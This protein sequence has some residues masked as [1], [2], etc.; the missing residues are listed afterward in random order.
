MSQSPTWDAL[1]IARDAR[2]S[3][4]PDAATEIMREVDEDL[5]A[6]VRVGAR[7]LN[8]PQTRE[9]WMRLMKRAGLRGR[10]G[11]P[12]AM[13]RVR[14]A[15]SCDDGIEFRMTSWANYIVPI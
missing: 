12:D 9:D 6:Y 13:W 15:T 7:P 11:P 14:E 3:G 1:Q 8:L 2:L 4:R 10:L 5:A